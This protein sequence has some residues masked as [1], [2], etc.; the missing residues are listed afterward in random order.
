MPRTRPP[1]SLAFRNQPLELIRAG[2]SPEDLGKEYE[3]AAQ[4][5]R[6][7]DA[8]ADRDEGHRQDG[9]PSAEREELRTLRRENRRLRAER[10]MLAKAA[11]WFAQEPP[12]VPRKPAR[13]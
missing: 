3:P 4:T 2:P 1:Y 12:S 9:L 8:Q 5:L 10:E 13:P 7:G 11:A 6:S